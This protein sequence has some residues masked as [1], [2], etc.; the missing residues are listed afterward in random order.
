MRLI[1]R[2]CLFFCLACA[3][4][5]QDEFDELLRDDGLLGAEELLGDEEFLGNKELE[6]PLLGQ[7]N[8]IELQVTAQREIE[9]EDEEGEIELVRIF[10]KKI[11]PGDEVIYT[12]EYVNQGYEAADRVIVSCPIPEG[13]RYRKFSAVGDGA[14][15]LFSIDNGLTFD[16]PANLIVRND[17]GDVTKAKTRHYTH[18][19]WRLLK[20]VSAGGSG[21]VSFRASL[22][23][24]TPLPSRGKVP[25]AVEEVQSEEPAENRTIE[26]EFLDIVGE[27]MT[28][29]FSDYRN[30]EGNVELGEVV[31][32]LKTKQHNTVNRQP[33]QAGY[34]LEWRRRFA[35]RVMIRQGYPRREAM[36]TAR[37]MEAYG[38][39]PDPP[40]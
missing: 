18:I 9:E 17:E 6:R 4:P 12:I 1:L 35:I 37:D 34:S 40:R 11:L 26:E 30:R 27:L 14:E 36:A 13:M 20:H 24:S 33:G 3:V 25:E 5:A 38:L 31:E 22:E 10:A 39:L 8:R 2:L 29:G 32:R 7:E 19:R 15:I 28:A 16:E 21:S 23:A